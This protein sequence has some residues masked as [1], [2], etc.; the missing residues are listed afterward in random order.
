MRKSTRNLLLAGAL[1]GPL[2]VGIGT[3]EAIVRDGYDIRRHSLSLLA[4]GHGGWVHSTMMVT[5]GLLTILGAL[6]LRRA[7]VGSRW[8][9]G[10]ILLYGAGIAGGGLMRADPMDGFPIGTPLGVPET[11]TWHSLG[12]IVA[13]FLGFVGLIVACLV[14]A[15]RLRRGRWAV[16]SLVTG[17]LYLLAIVGISTSGGTAAGNLGFTVAVIAGW[18]WLTL[19]MTHARTEGLR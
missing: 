6:A 17:V 3:I 8:V 13:G 18:A 9:W 2:Y 16:F 14:L 15:R 1:A 4:N 10:G 19:L 12:H 5:T 11:S 7:G